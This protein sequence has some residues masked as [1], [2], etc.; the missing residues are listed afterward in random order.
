MKFRTE[1][2]LACPV[3]KVVEIFENQDYNILW[4]SN[5]VSSRIC[6]IDPEQSI[7][8]FAINGRSV[9]VRIRNVENSLPNCIETFAELEG[10]VQKTTHNFTQDFN[11]NTKWVVE[12]EVYSPHVILKLSMLIAPSIYKKRTQSYVQDFKKFVEQEIYLNLPPEAA[13]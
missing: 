10:L 7:N 11:D 6:E 9:E 13:E 8:V 4:Q 3:S 2:I 1:I 12:S 5:L